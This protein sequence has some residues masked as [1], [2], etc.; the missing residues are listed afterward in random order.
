M[1]PGMSIDQ[2]KAGVS[3]IRN[4]VI[5]RVFGELDLIEEWGSGYKRI[6][7]ACQK[8][9]YPEPIWEEYG[10]VMRVTFYPHSEL[11]TQISQPAPSRH[12]VGTKLAPSQNQVIERELDFDAAAKKLSSFCEQG[13]SMSEMMTFLGWSDRTKFRNKFINPLIERGVIEMTIPDKPK[14][15]SQR[16]IL[17]VVGRQSR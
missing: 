15:S 11:A 8:D 1:P 13:R 12:Q 10:T 9:G 2:F 5:A 6:R 14:S 4:P 16:Y 3:R 7:E 17:T